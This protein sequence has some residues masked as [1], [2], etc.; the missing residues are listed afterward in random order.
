MKMTL[1]T[2]R[3]MISLNSTY[4]MMDA[5]SARKTM[6]TTQ[7]RLPGVEYPSRPLLGITG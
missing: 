7:Y 3:P 2:Y 4:Q 6:S 5:V 1:N